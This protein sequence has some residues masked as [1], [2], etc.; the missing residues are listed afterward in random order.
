MSMTNRLML[1]LDVVQQ[2]SFT[3]AATLHDMDNSALSKQIKKLESDLGVQLLNRS[4]R[5]FS[6]TSAGEEILE[7]AHV[8]KDTL[9]QVQLV[10]D[11]YQS[12]PKGILRI[13]SPIFFGHGYL[14]PVISQFMKTYPD[15]QIV[16][17]LS[18]KKNDIISENIDL[19]FRLGKLQ[20]SNLI[21]KKI[22][23]TNFILIASNDFI[24]EHGNPTT[25]QELIKLPSVL[26]TNG[27]MTV[28]Q[29]IINDAIGSPTFNTHKMKGSYKVSDVRTTIDAV[30]DGLGYAM[31]ELANLHN[32]LDELGLS[33]L[34]PDY[35]I[36][37]KDTAIYA[38]YP[39]RKHTKIAKLFVEEVQ[40][41][42][43]TPPRW[44]VYL[45]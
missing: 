4:T 23:D 42:I 7:Q 45:K 19:A 9:D 36:S 26:Y 29:L 8:L 12:K 27:D 43:G 33:L 5:S 34:L 13:T 44:E 35:D 1:F 16:H 41:Y 15:I 14:Q 3:K 11:S 18:D 39:H 28:D 2:G 20:D 25:P 17:V 10:A 32:S 6:L 38:I 30:R 40:K 22:A 37:T 31:I 24:K 21:A